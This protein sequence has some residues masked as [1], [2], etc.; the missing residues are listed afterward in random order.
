MLYLKLPLAVVVPQ[1]HEQ[2]S[3]FSLPVLVPALLSQNAFNS[4]SV[5][6]SSS[7]CWITDTIASTPGLL[8]GDALL[9][10]PLQPLKLGPVGSP[11]KEY[12]ILVDGEAVG[13]K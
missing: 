13:F 7:S 1:V 3:E 9:G 2:R 12:L 11:T 10:L 8:F 6:V 5:M 4:G